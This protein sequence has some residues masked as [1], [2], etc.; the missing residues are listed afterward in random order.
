[1]HSDAWTSGG[2]T[3]ALLRLT[4]REGATQPPL[5]DARLARVVLG[6]ALEGP[7]AAR[8]PPLFVGEARVAFRNIAQLRLGCNSVL[9]W[10]LLTNT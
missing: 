3:S 7:T 4:I 10:C 2:V 6:Q 9:T 8:T 1:M 5:I